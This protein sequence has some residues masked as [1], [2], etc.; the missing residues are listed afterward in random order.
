MA[1]YPELVDKIIAEKAANG[2]E[3][4]KVQELLMEL[5]ENY[6]KQEDPLMA[7]ICRLTAEYIAE[8]DTFDLVVEVEED[9]EEMVELA[10]EETTF[11]YLMQLISDCDNKYNREEIKEYRTQLQGYKV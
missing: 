4:P 10:D 2:F 3:S 11:E 6:L 9:E 7:K 5:R 8:N 1:V